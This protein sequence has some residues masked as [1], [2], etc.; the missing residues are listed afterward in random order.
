MNRLIKILILM[1]AVPALC[2]AQSDVLQTFFSNIE[3]QTLESDFTFTITEQGGQ[4]TNIAGKITM[5]GERFTANLMNTE[6]AFDG[7]TLYTYSEDNDELTLSTPT[8]EELRESN[9]L[10][11]AKA[12]T[13]TYKPT[14]TQQGSNW[15]VSI[16]PDAQQTG[17]REFTLILRKSDLIPLSATMRE[18]NFN[19]TTL[20]LRNQHLST[21]LPDF[22]INKPGAF[23]N[24][25]R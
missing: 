9:P 25:L 17:V 11:F 4:P 12:L 22:M 3:K 20:T 2:F 14:V 18:T 5:R 7:K 10:L 15:L 13:E 1:M 6:V 8:M 19:T 24:D 16:K 21:T 23:I